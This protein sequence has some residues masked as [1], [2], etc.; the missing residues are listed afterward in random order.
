MGLS[1]KAI[2][3]ILSKIPRKSLVWPELLNWMDEMFVKSKGNLHQ[4]SLATEVKLNFL[5]DL[6]RK[7]SWW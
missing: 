2:L 1:P 7:G 6:H 5:V 3:D 4:K